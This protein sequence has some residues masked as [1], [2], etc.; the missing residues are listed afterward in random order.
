MKNFILIVT[1]L[2]IFNQSYAQTVPPDSGKT[3]AINFYYEKAG[4]FSEIKKNEVGIKSTFLKKSDDNLPLYYI[5]NMVPDGFVIVSA[6]KNVFPV[7]GYSFEGNYNENIENP[8]FSYFLE[9]YASQITDVNGKK[10][11]ADKKTAE[12]W[13]KYCNKDFSPELKGNEKAVPPLIF[14]TWNQDK[15]YNDLCPAD[16]GGPGGHTYA[17]CVATALG[18]IMY[19]YRWP[20]TGTGSYTYN[21][22]VYG[23]ISADFANTTYDWNLMTNNL[24]NVNLEVAKLLFHLGVSVDMNYGPNGSGMWN[25][26]GAYTLKT[27]FKY[28]PQTRYI[29]RDSTTLNWDSLVIT[30]LDN[31]KPL[32]YAGWS[33]TTFT[34]GHAFV[35]DGYQTTDFF[36]FN[37]GWGGTYNGFFYLDQLNPGGANFN[38]LQELIVDIYPDT[39]N[40]TYPAYCNGYSMLNG[41]NGTFSDGSGN[42]PYQGSSSCSWLLSPDCGT[43]IKLV[44]DRFS[45]ADGDSVSIFDGTNNLS[46]VL[47]RFNSLNQPTTTETSPYTTLESTN[48]NMYVVFTSNNSLE[49][50]GFNASYSVKYCSVDTSINTSGSVSDGSGTCDYEKSTNCRWYIIPQGAQSITLNFTEF[51]LASDNTGDYVKIYKNSI[52]SGN[53]IATFDYAN[54]P[55]GPLTIQAP[56][57]IIRFITNATT[58]AGG[59]S[60]DYSSSTT[61]IPETT[62]S[63]NGGMVVFPNPFRENAIIRFYSAGSKSVSIKLLDLSGKILLNKLYKTDHEV[64]EVLIREIIDEILPGCY[65]L[66]VET[67]NNEFIRKV[68][69]LPEIEK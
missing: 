32:Y 36:H 33:D 25:H 66:K 34:S 10:L 3:V 37:W 59:W 13:K 43:N 50:D 22:P 18:Q 53:S 31:K 27:Y 1:T 51:N 8:G 15:Y 19:Y 42:K 63:S 60:L 38:L 62:V 21:H 11:E 45:L 67:E 41:N 16:A 64:T 12:N 68:I 55:G 54:P 17:G 5:F 49:S 29:F 6:Q 24:T 56:V 28:G 48:N 46:P 23:I 7:L 69:R 35:C 4:F 65:L 57:V 30:N 44:F 40:Y 20:L 52:T 26:K 58:Q 47:A 2:L 61:G 14:S 9:I 39:I